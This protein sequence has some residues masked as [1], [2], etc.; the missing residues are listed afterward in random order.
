MNVSYVELYNEKV[1]DLLC[2]LKI[3]DR[4]KG[5]SI[6]NKVRNILESMQ[7]EG[8]QQSF[9]TSKSSPNNSFQ[10][11]HKNLKI[12]EDPE[13]GVSV[14]NLSEIAVQDASELMDL[15]NLGNKRRVVANTGA[16]QFSSRSHAILIFNIEGY[17]EVDELGNQTIV[18]SKLQ[19]IDLAGS[20]RSY[21]TQSTG[22]RMVEG[23][24]INKSLLALGKCI[25]ILADQS[26]QASQQMP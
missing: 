4:A 12:V 14:Q 6:K 24:L 16:H 7:S 26:T 9:N 18:R 20:E 21:T 5:G 25:N 23:S 11:F 22:Q 1:I 15:I 10:K 3:S 8:Q 13:K 2:D 19:M 17:S